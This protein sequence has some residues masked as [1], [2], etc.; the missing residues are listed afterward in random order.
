[1]DDKTYKQIKEML[2]STMT[3]CRMLTARLEEASRKCEE[4]AALCTE[5][6]HDLAKRGDGV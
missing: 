2:D 3:E 4:F 6:A 1:M 5:I